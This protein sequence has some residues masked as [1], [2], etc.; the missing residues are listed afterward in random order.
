MTRYK[1]AKINFYQLRSVDVIRSSKLPY[2]N[3]CRVVGVVISI[4]KMAETRN[5][6]AGFRFDDDDIHV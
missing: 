3:I 6:V 2:I 4:T 5:G 1:T